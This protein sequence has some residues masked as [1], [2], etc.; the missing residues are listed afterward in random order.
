MWEAL[1]CGADAFSASSQLVRACAW[2]QFGHSRLASLHASLQLRFHKPSS[3]YPKLSFDSKARPTSLSFGSGWL[4]PSAAER[5]LAAAKLALLQEAQI[6]E[7]AALE[8]LLRL[9]P[10]CTWGQLRNIWLQHTAE[11]LLRGALVRGEKR[12]AGDMLERYKMLLTATDGPADAAWMP[13]LEL[14][15]QDSASNMNSIQPCA[16]QSAHSQ[17]CELCI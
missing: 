2:E 12:R 13:S 5:V 17:A 6:G 7:K 3:I 16:F 4:R 9:R 8:S 1:R 14:L 11:V 10:L 15:L